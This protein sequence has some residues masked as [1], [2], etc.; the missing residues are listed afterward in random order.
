M[1][2]SQLR[3]TLERKAIE[4][5]LQF[6][7]PYPFLPPRFRNISE[8]RSM[9]L[10]IDQELT[11]HVR[12]EGARLAEHHPLTVGATRQLI[13]EVMR[14]MARYRRELRVYSRFIEGYAEEPFEDQRYE[15]FRLIKKLPTAVRD[16]TKK[17]DMEADTIELKAK[18]LAGTS[19]C[20]NMGGESPLP[21]WDWES[22]E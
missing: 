11:I 18:L 16:E 10:L 5:D 14:N 15:A 4:E 12:W 9:I 20:S 19:A 1:R 3:E 8:N 13:R 6:L 2:K 17:T 21:E 7:I 22:V